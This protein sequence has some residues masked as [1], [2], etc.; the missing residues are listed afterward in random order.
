[1]EN[2]LKVQIRK[3]VAH[4][5][6]AL[7]SVGLSI[8]FAVTGGEVSGTGLI[9]GILLG[10]ALILEFPMCIPYCAV[11]ISSK[12]CM[13]YSAFHATYVSIFLLIITLLNIVSVVLLA[14]STATQTDAVGQKVYGGIV[15]FLIFVHA[16]T[17]LGFH[18]LLC[19]SVFLET[20]P[21]TA[22]TTFKLAKVQCDDENV[23]NKLTSG[24][25]EDNNQITNR[26]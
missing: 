18:L 1:M 10:A 13:K 16:V 12:R 7:L 15:T 4:V 5:G 22:A 2:A 26:T 20:K 23:D 11:I 14:I 8:P 6:T 9:S 24:H 21:A 3:G 17:T 25:G 19:T